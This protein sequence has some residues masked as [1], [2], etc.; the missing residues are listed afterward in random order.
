M[1]KYIIKR[2]LLLIP[3]LIGVSI[4]VFVVMHAFTADP[5]ANILGQHAKREQIEALRQQLGLNDPLY[6]QYWHF[7]KDAVRGNLGQS[8]F[9]K[10]SVTKELLSRFPALW[11][12]RW[13]L[14]CSPPYSV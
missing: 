11:N 5:A 3:V 12:W 14:Y 13:R 10:T 8:L 2:L 1:A 7:F 6:V 4:V 9:T